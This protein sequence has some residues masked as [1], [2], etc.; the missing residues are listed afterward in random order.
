MVSSGLSGRW[1]WVLTRCPNPDLP[2]RECASPTCGRPIPIKE[3]RSAPKTGL[4]FFQSRGGSLTLSA[5]QPSPYRQ[6]AIIPLY[7]SLKN[8]EGWLQGESKSGSLFPN[9]R[10]SIKLSMQSQ[11]GKPDGILTEIANLIPT[12]HM[13][14][15]LHH[16]H[17]NLPYIRM[18]RVSQQKFTNKFLPP[19]DTISSYSHTKSTV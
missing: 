15:P 5:L 18:P 11:N 12:I 9:L 13:I 17:P 10:S 19:L 6:R 3:R 14:A 7:P 2:K 8:R 1:A 16:L 4:T